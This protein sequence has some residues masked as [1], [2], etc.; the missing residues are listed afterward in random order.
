MKV[1]STL[2]LILF[3]FI[4]CQNRIQKADDTVVAKVYDTE[5]MRS[6]IIAIIPPHSSKDDSILMSQNYLRN[7]ITKQ[8]LLH[9]AIDNLSDEEKNIRKQVEDYRTS[10][11]IHQYKQKLIAQKLSEEIENEQVEKYYKDNKEN[12]I[13]ST[14]IVKAVFF[15]IPKTASNLD[16]VRKWYKSENEK[17]Q[18]LL[19][20]YCISNA[21]KYGDFNNKWIELKYLLNLFPGNAPVQENEIRYTKHIEKE[22]EENYYF[23]KISDICSEHKIAPLDYVRDEIILILKN[24]KKIRFESELEKQINEEAIRK[25]HVKIY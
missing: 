21:K 15:V 24:K 5:L 8:L 20:D 12:F 19:D 16:K 9:K 11:L 3:F 13:L 25:N 4:A 18:E 7:W 14:P 22:N 2:L 17:D 10:L 6:E 23:L 1:L